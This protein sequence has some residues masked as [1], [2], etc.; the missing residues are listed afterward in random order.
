MTREEAHSKVDMLGQYTGFAE[1]HSF[2]EDVYDDF[3]SRT[4]ENCKHFNILDY[5]ESHGRCKNRSLTVH[6]R[7][8]PKSFGCNKWERK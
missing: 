8:V 6:N 2:I 5:T 7:Q 4:C 3:E 1:A